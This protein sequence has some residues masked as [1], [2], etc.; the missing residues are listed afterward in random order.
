MD[1]K[2]IQKL[3]TDP[4]LINREDIEKIEELLLDYPYAQSLRLL[5]LYSLR[6]FDSVKF[7]V[8]LQ[9]AAL[10]IADRKL[11][12]H[13]ASEDEQ[14]TAIK[15]RPKEAIVDKDVSENGCEGEEDK[16]LTLIDTFLS[17]VDQDDQNVDGIELATDYTGY[18]LEEE[19]KHAEPMEGQELIDDFLSSHDDSTPV[20]PLQDPF[21]TPKE[22]DEVESPLVTDVSENDDEGFFTETLAK[23]YVKQGR[24]VKALEILK[25]LSLKYPNKNAYFA[26]QIRFLEKLIINDKSK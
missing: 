7:H 5:Y 4:Q 22:V 20:V 15:T 21:M 17:Q 9:K 14:I 11:L 8:E 24:Y 25:K 19:A 2:Q 1:N 12:F 16:T 10:Y 26:D 3:L 18:L 23:I 6:N 13:L